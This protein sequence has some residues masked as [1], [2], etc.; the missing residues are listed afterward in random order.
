MSNRRGVVKGRI[1][2]AA[3]ALTGN[4]KLPAQEQTGQSK[5]KTAKK[6]TWP[7]QEVLTK[8][9]TGADQY[10]QQGSTAAA[11]RA[12]I[13]ISGQDTRTRGHVSARCKRS[14]ASRDAKS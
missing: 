1:T 5:Q 12:W 11:N 9:N 8:T 14:Q 6:L 13:K 7:A 10:G 2:E 3:G 4:D